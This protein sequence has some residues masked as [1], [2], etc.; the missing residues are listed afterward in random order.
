MRVSLFVT[1]L[2]D[3]FWPSV[4]TG[5]VKVLEDAGCEVSFDGRQTCCGQPAFNS[6]YRSEARKL[7]ERFITIFEEAHVDAIVCPSGSCT[8]MVHHVRE[9][10]PD[11]RSW[12]ERAD[13]L[14]ERTFEF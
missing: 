3:Q 9:L 6:G 1:C 7:A 2:I 8:A 5:V 10:F 14:A 4:G 13:S 11:D 12:R